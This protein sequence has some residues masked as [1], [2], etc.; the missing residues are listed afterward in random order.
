MYIQVNFGRNI[1]NVAMG[2]DEWELFQGRV[3]FSIY[4]AANDAEAKF[5]VLDNIEDHYGKGTWGEVTEESCHIS[6]YWGEGFDLDLLRAELTKLK[7]WYKQ[8]AIA[9]I[10]GSELI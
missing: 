6:S 10:V 3:A 1:D 5:S 2:T 4:M 8:D 9:L 7:E